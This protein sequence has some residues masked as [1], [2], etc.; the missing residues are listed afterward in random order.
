M[1]MNTLGIRGM[2]EFIHRSVQ[3]WS[4]TSVSGQ[5]SAGLVEISIGAFAGE[6]AA[7]VP[8]RHKLLR[9]WRPVR[10]R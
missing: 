9:F 5:L 4:L 10:R 6:A 2:G 7:G 3:T 1:I 8:G